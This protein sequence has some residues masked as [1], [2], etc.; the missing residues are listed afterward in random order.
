MLRITFATLVS[1][2]LRKKPP[3][4]S[5]SPLTPFSCCPKSLLHFTARLPPPPRLF[6]LALFISTHTISLIISCQDHKEPKYFKG[7]Y[8]VFTLLGLF[9]VVVMFYSLLS[10]KHAYSYASM[11]LKFPDFLNTFG[12]YFSL[13]FGD[14]SFSP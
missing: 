2:I 12:Y 13:F 9:L 14:F 7:Q 6:I 4:S 5:C 10:Y 3:K 8:S 11:K 1:S